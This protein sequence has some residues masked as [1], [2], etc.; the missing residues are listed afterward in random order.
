MIVATSLQKLFYS[1]LTSHSLYIQLVVLKE[2]LQEIENYRNIHYYVLQFGVLKRLRKVQK[3]ICEKDCIITSDYF[4]LRQETMTL[5]G[6]FF[7]EIATR[8]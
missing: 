2:L 5:S 8:K 3:N 4:I 7:T 6:I 1:V